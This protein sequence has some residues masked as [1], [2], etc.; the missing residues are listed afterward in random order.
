MRFLSLASTALV[1]TP[2]H[3]HP[4]SAPYPHIL[5]IACV[6][7]YYKLHEDRGRGGAVCYVWCP[8]LY[9]QGLEWG[10]HSIDVSYNHE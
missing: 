3:T 6:P 5:N 4:S 1:K 2:G 7:S 9:G 8:Q 10:T